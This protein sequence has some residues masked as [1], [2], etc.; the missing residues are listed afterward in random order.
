[1][2]PV[3][4]QSGYNFF[5][6]LQVFGGVPRSLFVPGITFSNEPFIAITVIGRNQIVRAN[7]QKH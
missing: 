1:M 4:R 6:I 2:V 5:S 3:T 7:L